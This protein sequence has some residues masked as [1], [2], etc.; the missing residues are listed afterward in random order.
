MPQPSPFRDVWTALG[1]L[2]ERPEVEDCPEARELARELAE[3]IYRA[4]VGWQD[5]AKATRDQQP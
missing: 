4:E 5:S 1:K 2:R 3:A